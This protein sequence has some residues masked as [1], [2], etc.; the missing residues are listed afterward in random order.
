M[1]TA[2]LFSLVLVLPACADDSGGAADPATGAT[3][4]EAG[5]GST[6][7]PSAGSTG[8]SVGGSSDSVGDGSESGGGESTGAAP[9]DPVPSDG[10]GGAGLSAG[11]HD[12]IAVEYEGVERSYNVF[13]P[14]VHDGESPIPLVMMMHGF[15]SNPT[16]QA[17]FS[18]MNSTAMANGLA[19]AY[20]AGLNDSWNGGGCCGD[21]LENDI[22]DVGFIRAATEHV[23][24]TLCID[25]Q[26]IFASGMS[27][28]GFMSYRLACEASDLF[29]AIAP[30]AGVLGIE[31]ESCAPP[32]AVPVL[33]THGT[34]DALVPYDG[35]G[36]TGSP[37]AAETVEHWLTHNGCSP[38]PA[39][40]TEIEPVLCQTWSGCDDGG[41][42]TFCTLDGIGHCWPG[43]G[44]CP[45]G[46][47]T[48]VW[49]AS[50][51]MA[52]FFAAH[53]MPAG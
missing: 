49:N 4:A 35:G 34:L 25:R 8:A 15:G 20:P 28:G 9:V 37:S 42:V 30:V 40:T 36:T 27:N 53:P 6:G 5:T 7:S 33:H 13:V 12:N 44:V 11:T 38:E 1:R 24:S 22:D 51:A 26:R 21:S 23:A 52:D 45:F 50:D 41:Q 39:I 16:E 14:D 32:R 2:V 46:D 10:C 29:A 47:S 43:Q 18:Q 48:T 17:F 19:V 31:P 3:G